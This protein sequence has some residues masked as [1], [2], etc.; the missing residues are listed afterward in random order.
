MR[1]VCVILAGILVAGCSSTRGM[2]RPYLGEISHLC[3]LENYRVT[4]PNFQLDL[5]RQLASRHIEVDVVSRRSQCEHPY[6]LEY[7]ARRSYGIV[8]LVELDLYR[9]GKRIGY[10]DWD[11]NR[12]AA[13]SDLP[14]STLKSVEY[15]QLAEALSGLFGEIRLKPCKQR[16]RPSSVRGP[17]RPP[18]C[19][20]HQ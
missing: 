15:W 12:G 14:K 4:V 8:A 3:V 1:F 13:L 6:G 7:V 18:R 2:G 17:S 20:S 11:A 19:L 10:V 16:V 5:E 9:R